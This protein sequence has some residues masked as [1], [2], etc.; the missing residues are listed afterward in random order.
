MKPIHL[1]ILISLVLISVLSCCTV[2]KRLY[3]NGYYVKKTSSRS[4]VTKY[5]KEQGQKEKKVSNENS[6]VQTILPAFTDDEAAKPWASAD[7]KALPKTKPSDA[8]RCDSLFLKDG[9]VLEV[10]IKEIGTKDIRY[11]ICDFQEGPDYLVEKFRVSSIRFSNG[12]RELFKESTPP[13]AKNRTNEAAAP[14][15][16]EK[17]TNAAL[18]LSFGILGIYPLVLIGSV[19]GIIFGVLALD[20][21]K[22]SPGRYSNENIGKVGL[23]LSIGGIV[24][25]V[26]LIFLFLLL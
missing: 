3:R 16:I 8:E 15:G 4:P 9:S 24:F 22:K 1:Q 23:G 20:E 18:A 6:R 19:I 7:T 13:Q 17:S 5:T 21:F 25:W 2:E 12:T 10:K 14:K 11:K 26:F